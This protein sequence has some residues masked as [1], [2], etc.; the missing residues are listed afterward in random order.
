MNNI[1][2][3]ISANTIK[4][5][6]LAG[7]TGTISISNRLE[8][9]KLSPLFTNGITV[10][11]EDEGEITMTPQEIKTSLYD[12]EII[13]MVDTIKSILIEKNILTEDEFNNLYNI[14]QEKLSNEFNDKITANKVLRTISDSNNI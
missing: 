4:P 5:T 14:N 2:N 13:A 1:T 7:P 3:K 10:K 8:N 6:S 9:Y 11:K 12:Y